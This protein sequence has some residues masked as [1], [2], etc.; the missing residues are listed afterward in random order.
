MKRRFGL[1][2][3]PRP[4]CKWLPHVRDMK[5]LCKT[6]SAAIQRYPARPR[7]RELRLRVH[8]TLVSVFVAV[9]HVDQ[10]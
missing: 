1:Y 3:A 8:D 9:T 6:N 5:N 7:A 2:M 4:L 10:Y